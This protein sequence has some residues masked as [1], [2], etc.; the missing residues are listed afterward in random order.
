[1]MNA[2]P[3][4]IAAWANPASR[5]NPTGAYAALTPASNPCS[6]VIRLT[7]EEWPSNFKQRNLVT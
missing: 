6:N 1:M 3:D 7:T 5:L 4:E 2:M